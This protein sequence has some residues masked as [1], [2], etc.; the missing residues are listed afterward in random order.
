MLISN[1]F[2]SIFNIVSSRYRDVWETHI[3]AGMKIRSKMKISQLLFSVFNREIYSAEASPQP[4]SGNDRV[5]GYEDDRVENSKLGKTLHRIN[6]R[7]KGNSMELF[8]RCSKRCT[9]TRE[10]GFTFPTSNDSLADTIIAVTLRFPRSLEFS[11]W[12]FENL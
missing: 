4:F 12:S 1:S 8:S 3:R 7:L 6:G 10:N 2:S 5:H 9:N 11:L